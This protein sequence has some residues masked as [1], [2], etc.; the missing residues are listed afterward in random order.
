MLQQTR[1]LC[2]WALSL[3]KHVAIRSDLYC[4]TMEQVSPADI[5]RMLALWRTGDGE[6]QD[7]LWPLIYDELMGLARG[8]LHRQGQR[9]RHGTTTLVHEAFLRLIG[10]DS[11][12]S[13]ADRG[14]F[15]AVAVRAM[16]FVL[17]DEAR[18]RLAKK[19]EGEAKAAEMPEEP[20]D[21]S[22]HK[23][24]DV[25]A[26]HTAIEKLGKINPRYERLVEARYFAGFSVD[27]TAELLEVSR[28]TVVRDWRAARS[29]LFSELHHS[30]AASAL[31]GTV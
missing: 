12:I 9:G 2:F 17:V 22:Q 4:S 6:A 27:E 11:D 18:R 14:H 23:P 1:S 25:L 26:I 19:R 31:P 24:E 21:P 30:Q 29:W 28:P 13:Y 10:S 5:T 20:A 16:R 3:P 15:Y 8:V 7:K